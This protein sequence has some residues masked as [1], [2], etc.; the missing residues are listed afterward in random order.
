VNVQILEA[1]LP[2]VKVIAAQ[3]FQDE[4]GWFTESWNAER[5]QA[6]GIDAV[7]VQY[8]ASYSL[9]GVLRGMHYQWPHEQGKLISV[10]N[11]VVYDA[12][13]DVRV[14]SATF[15]RWYGCELS[16]DNGRQL[17]VPPGYAHGFLVLSDAA[18]VQYSCTATYRAEFDRALRQ[19]E[20]RNREHRPAGT[21]H[22]GFGE[23]SRRANAGGT[24]RARRTAGG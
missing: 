17:W 21:A 11:G 18:L 16:L 13:V 14:G 9:R 15:G 8:N 3:R 12:V 6:L 1:P 2:G 22:A 4:R 23:G 10:L 20:R 24:A 19:L 7:F 5:Y